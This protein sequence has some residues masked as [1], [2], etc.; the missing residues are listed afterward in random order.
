MRALRPVVQFLVFSIVIYV[1]LIVRWPGVRETYRDAYLFT[2]ELLFGHYGDEGIVLFKTY[3]KDQAN[4]AK[5]TMGKRGV[6][7]KVSEIKIG[8]VSE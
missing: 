2:A 4:D 6:W 3:H 5:I 7:A 8:S 1:L